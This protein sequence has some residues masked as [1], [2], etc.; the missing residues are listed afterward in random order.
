MSDPAAALKDLN[1]ALRIIPTAELHTNRGVVE[2][3]VGDSTDAMNDYQNAIKIDPTY[4]LAYF[5]AA[6][7]YFQNRQFIQVIVNKLQVKCE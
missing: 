6:N 2:Q 1:A 4:S 7:L 3:F 5:N